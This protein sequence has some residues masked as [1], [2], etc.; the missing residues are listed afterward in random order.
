MAMVFKL[1]KNGDTL[2]D[3]GKEFI[4]RGEFGKARDYLQKS[5]EK[6]GGDNDCAAVKIALIDL[7]SQTTNPHMYGVLIQ[8]LEETDNEEFEFGLTMIVRDELKVECELTKRK[9][10]LIQSGGRGSSLVAR[11]EQLQQLAM[12]FQSKI[13]ERTLVIP[14]LFNRDSTV[15]GNTEFY[16]LMAIAYES[17]AR[18][19]VWDNPSQAAEYEQIAAGY[20]QQN[21]QSGD[22]NMARIQ[23]YSTTCKCWMCGRIATGEGIHFYK[24]DAEVSPALDKQ[25]DTVRAKPEGDDHIYICLACYSAVSKR[26]DAISRQYYDKALQE[27]RAMEMRLQA[28]IMALQS[29]ISMARMSR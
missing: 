11:G 25:A 28:E 27:M 24:A 26:S 20:R 2:Y 5:M 16:N 15:T 10:E 23:A 21:G 12:D 6:D 14:E 9:L 17:M 18:G 1:F 19:V 29:Q 7:S 8:R 4:K 3:E 22:E 13:G